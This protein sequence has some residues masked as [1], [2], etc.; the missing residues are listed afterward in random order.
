MDLEFTLLR[1]FLFEL[2]LAHPWNNL[3]QLMFVIQVVAPLGDVPAIFLALLDGA[4]LTI[5]HH[6]GA[7]DVLLLNVVAFNPRSRQLIMNQ[8][9][10]LPR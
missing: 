9:V 3:M 4:S 6:F 7:V 5:L 2:I 1:P 8:R 10:D